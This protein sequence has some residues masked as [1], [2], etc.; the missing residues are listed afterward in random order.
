MVN[1]L[2]T[3]PNPGVSGGCNAFHFAA[4]KRKELVKASRKNDSLCYLSSDFLADSYQ[5]E[6]ELTVLQQQAAAAAMGGKGEKKK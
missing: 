2:K 5:E 1:G 3:A 6:R 4:G